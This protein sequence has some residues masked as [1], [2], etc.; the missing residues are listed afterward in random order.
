MPVTKFVIAVHLWLGVPL[1]PPSQ[2]CVCYTLIDTF[3][4]HL[5]GCS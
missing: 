5:L 4:D 3:G 2:L 1:L